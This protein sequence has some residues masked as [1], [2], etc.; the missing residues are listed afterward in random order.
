MKMEDGYNLCRSTTIREISYT[1][2][3]T[4]FTQLTPDSGWNEEYR[5]TFK[6]NTQTQFNLLEL[7]E[8]AGHAVLVKCKS[9]EGVLQMCINSIQRKKGRAKI[10]RPTALVLKFDANLLEFRGFHCSERKGENV[11]KSNS[12]GD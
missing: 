3:Q 8:L 10:W 11:G 5:S 1:F 9:K 2:Q 12:G 4:Q 7:H 6:S